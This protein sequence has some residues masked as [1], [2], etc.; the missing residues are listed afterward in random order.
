MGECE[1]TSQQIFLEKTVAG[2]SLLEVLV[3]IT[4]V[5]VIVVG[6]LQCMAYCLQISLAADRH[7]RDSLSRW[8]QVQELRSQRN[9]QGA[10]FM[11]L[12]HARPMSY[13]VVASE[14]EDDEGGWEVLRASK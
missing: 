9:T 3:S 14:S 2:F 1:M 12:L 4:I 10:P 6:V 8:N 13:W 5:T 7:W 11:V